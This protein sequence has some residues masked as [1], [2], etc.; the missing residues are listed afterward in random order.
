MRLGKRGEILAVTRL[1]SVMRDGRNLTQS[2]R[3]DLRELIRMTPS[4]SPD[5]GN[6]WEVL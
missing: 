6:Y 2:M 3:K 4:G 1:D 5:P